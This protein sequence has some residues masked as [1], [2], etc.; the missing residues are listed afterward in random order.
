MTAIVTDVKYRM[1]LALI[2]DLAD[3][4]V[5]VIACEYEG[6]RFP[7]GFESKAVSERVTLP[8]ENTADA[9][10]RLCKKH[11]GAALMPVGAKTLAMLCE[12]R[13]DF[14]NA[15]LPEPDAL[16]LFN[17]KARVNALAKE[18]GVPAPEA[19]EGLPAVVKP[20]CG[21]KFG[22]AAAERYVIARTESERD[23]AVSRFTALTGEPPLTQEYLE[24]AA[25]GCSVVAREGRVLASVC[26]RRVREWPVSGG[27]S[28]CA[29]RIEAPE[30]ERYAAKMIGYCNYTGLAMFEFK[31]GKLLEINPRVWG[32]Y[33]LVRAA[34]TNFS[35]VWY[36]AALGEH[37]PF[38]HGR[39]ARM[40]FYPA[41][42]AAA[43]GYLK[44]GA[45]GKALRAAV[46][47]VDPRVKNGIA[48]RGDN[49]PKRMYYRSLKERK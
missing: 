32:T 5:K 30:L 7:L 34:N 35:F 27:P 25:C 23:E 22:L 26:H 39:P 14:A 10:L 33:P 4:G 45:P 44:R 38:E 41:D 12:R 46:D 16:S 1:S 9:L 13:A 48:Q 18:L 20:A 42:L 15:L 43:L 21:E 2:R 6:E 31:G 49:A 47:A 8:R 11:P 29:E 36:K 40:A 17:D 24:G 3:A 19:T 28:S 37:V